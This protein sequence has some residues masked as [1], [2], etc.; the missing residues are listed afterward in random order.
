MLQFCLDGIAAI[1]KAVLL[2][3]AAD[4]LSGIASL[5]GL[6]TSFTGLSEKFTA[7]GEAMVA[8]SNATTGVN[9]EQIKASAEAAASLAEVFNS[10]PKEGGWFQTV[11]GEQDLSGFSSKLEGFGNALTSYGNSVANLNVS[12]INN[13]VPA[14]NSL[15][16]ILKS[17]PNSGGKLQIVLGNKDMES[18]SNDLSGLGTALVN[19]GNS[20]ANLNAKAIKDSVPAAEGLAE[21]MKALP[22]SDGTWQKVFGKKNAS[23]F[24]G[25]LEAFGTSMKNLSDTLSE[26][27]FSYYDSAAA[28]LNH[29]TEAVTNFDIRSLNSIVTSIGSLGTKASTSFTTNVEQSTIKNA[30]DAPL[31]KAVSSV[32]SYMSKFYSAGSYLVTG[33]AN[34]IRDNIYRAQ[35]AAIDMSSSTELAARSR[36]HINSPSKVF[37][38]IGAGVPEGFAQGIERFS[39]LGTRAVESMSNDA[40]DSA[41]KVLSNINAVLTNDVN[42]QP[43]IRPVVDLSNVES[44]SDAISNMLSM[45]PTVSAFSNV[46]SISAMMNR[47][48]NGANDDVV[49]AIKDLGKTIGKASGDTYQINGITYDSGSE[50]SEAIQTLIRASIIEGRR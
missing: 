24:G 10:L 39:Y 17:L 4:F 40:I 9:S 30:F 14:A 5:I 18:F 49:S 7:I 8:F 44:S 15:V 48:Q 6:G 32:R 42:A 34:G 3:T 35:R 28:A 21:F 29:I 27:E 16:D 1:T 19:Y 12:A 47:N 22:S 33:F 43:M 36:L 41:S 26:V 2:L 37:R 46:S 11:F 25:Q 13:S 50:V 31:N 45:D 38:K 20:V 23:N